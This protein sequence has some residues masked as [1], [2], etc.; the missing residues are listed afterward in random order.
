MKKKLFT[1]ILAF[2]MM[3]SFIVEVYAEEAQDNY[4]VEPFYTNTS[5]VTANLRLSGATAICNAQN[6]MT[7]NKKSKITMTLQKSSDKSTYSKVKAWSQEST[8]KLVY[9]RGIKKA[10]SQFSS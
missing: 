9:G 4:G 6:V 8:E 7:K 1:I 5:L 10:K 3:T 2:V